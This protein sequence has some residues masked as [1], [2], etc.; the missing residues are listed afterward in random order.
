[1][2]LSL[3]KNFDDITNKEVYRCDH[4]SEG[5]GECVKISKIRMI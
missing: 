3:G 2:L 5:L 4:D 1:M